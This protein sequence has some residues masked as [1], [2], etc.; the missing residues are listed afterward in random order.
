MG[1]DLTGMAIH[2]VPGPPRVILS[3]IEGTDRLFE[4]LATAIPRRSGARFSSG[5]PVA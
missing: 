3:N 5:H 2:R 4:V 1:L